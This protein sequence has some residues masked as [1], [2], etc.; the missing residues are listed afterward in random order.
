MQ[1]ANSQGFHFSV[2]DAER[3]K[4]S[5]LLPW[6]EIPK[7]H[8][9]D[10]DDVE[11]A[12]YQ[13]ADLGDRNPYAQMVDRALFFQKYGLTPVFMSDESGLKMLVTSQEYINKRLH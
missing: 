11:S 1:Q 12:M 3:F 10:Q 5:N 13:Y 7:Y 6:Q 9:V 8:V 4:S 2:I